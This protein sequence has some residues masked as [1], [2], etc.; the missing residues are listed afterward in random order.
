MAYA[1][2][3]YTC[4]IR[5]A[6]LLHISDKLFVY[7]ESVGMSIGRGQLYISGVNY[8]IGIVTKQTLAS[9]GS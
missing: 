3:L 7:N 8:V 5:F 2:R 1:P 9:W 4:L 6:I